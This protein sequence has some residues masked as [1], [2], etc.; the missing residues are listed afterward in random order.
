MEA[1]RLAYQTL[2]VSFGS[3][4][5]ILL[6]WDRLGVMA[7]PAISVPLA[8]HNSQSIEEKNI[9]I[10]ASERSNDSSVRDWSE[11]EER[12]LVRKIDSIVMPLLMLAFFALQLDRGNM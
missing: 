7:T 10:A 3:L 11:D 12:K 2:R 9:A 4:P 5:S 1:S 6:A 8:I